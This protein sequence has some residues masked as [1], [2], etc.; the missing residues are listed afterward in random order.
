MASIIANTELGSVPPTSVLSVYVY[1]SDWASGPPQETNTIIACI[2]QD[3]MEAQPLNGGARVN[4]QAGRTRPVVL[5]GDDSGMDVGLQEYLCLHI[6][7]IVM[8]S[9]GC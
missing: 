8:S 6:I 4:T 5:N 3:K 1:L 7:W 2:S 9:L